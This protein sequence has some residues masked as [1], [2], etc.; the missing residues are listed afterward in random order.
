MVS[1]YKQYTWIFEDLKCLYSFSLSFLFS[2]KQYV[3]S[4]CYIQHTC[5]EEM[6][7]GLTDPPVQLTLLSPTVLCSCER[8]QPL[9]GGSVRDEQIPCVQTQQRV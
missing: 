5:M 6:K 4:W 1:R 8:S 9:E 7:A 3:A 2:Y